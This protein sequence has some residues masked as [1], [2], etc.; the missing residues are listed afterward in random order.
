MIEAHEL[1]KGLLV[2]WTAERYMSSWS[3]PCVVTEVAEGHFRVRSFDDGKETGPL[4]MHDVPGGDPSSRHEMRVC[5]KT[6]VRRYFEDRKRALEDRATKARRAVE[7]AE[8]SSAHMT[9]R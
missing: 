7:D 2:W 3:C 8:H 1:R 4:R 6:E 9:M 5:S